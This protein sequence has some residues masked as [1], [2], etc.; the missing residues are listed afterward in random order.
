[1]TYSHY[2]F[3]TFDNDRLTFENTKVKGGKFFY[4]RAT[5]IETGVKYIKPLLESRSARHNFN[6]EDA[7]G[8]ELLNN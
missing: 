5:D 1:M 6:L 2:K 3:S 4:N 7:L 8:I